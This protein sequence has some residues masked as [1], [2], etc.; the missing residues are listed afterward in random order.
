MWINS[1]F[2]NP[3]FVAIWRQIW[4]QKML[5]L[6]QMRYTGEYFFANANDLEEKEVNDT[7]WYQRGQGKGES[8]MD[9]VN[10]ISE[11]LKA[12]LF[13][14]EN[15]T[16]T[17]WVQLTGLFFCLV[18]EHKSSWKLLFYLFCCSTLKNFF[19]AIIFFFQWTTPRF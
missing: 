7:K 18:V 13:I 16:E 5:F 2:G 1:G 15:R 12:I 8:L 9:P 14:V 10:N 3:L 11:R 6:F 19:L 4:E 17:G